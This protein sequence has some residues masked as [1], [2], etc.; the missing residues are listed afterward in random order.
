MKIKPDNKGFSLIETLIY[1][2]LV[3]SILVSVFLTVYGLLLSQVTVG[4][5]T[6]TEEEANF[7]LRKIEWALTGSPTI[8]TPSLNAS[9]TVLLVNKY[10]YIQNP[11]AFDQSS[12]FIR[13]RTN[14][15]DPLPL[16]SASTVASNLSF[17]HLAP[18]GTSTI[19]TM[20]VSFTLDGKPFSSK[21][22]LQR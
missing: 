12:S 8:T 5:K 7:I 22:Y 18:Y 19:A 16:N 10:N 6:L 14:P 20:Q 13:M 15:N 9:G 3:S 1:L 2:G 21:I 11:I 4:N 17:Q